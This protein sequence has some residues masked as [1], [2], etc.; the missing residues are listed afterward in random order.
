MTDV[1]PQAWI[2]T[3]RLSNG[4]KIQDLIYETRSTILTRNVDLLMRGKFLPLPSPINNSIAVKVHFF[5]A[6][7]VVSQFPTLWRAKG[8]SRREERIRVY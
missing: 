4:T 3:A 7:L 2:E 5:K 8:T 1:A 6:A